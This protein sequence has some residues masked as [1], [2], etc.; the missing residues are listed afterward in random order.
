MSLEQQR[1]KELN[2]LILRAR[3]FRPDQLLASKM[4]FLSD[5]G[6]CPAL[7]DLVENPTTEFIIMSAETKGDLDTSMKGFLSQYIYP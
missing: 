4:S 2:I 5:I 7:K 1:E 3:A 6:K